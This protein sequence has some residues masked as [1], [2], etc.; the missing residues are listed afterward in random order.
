MA[1]E[2]GEKGK[3]VLITS[4]A[5]RKPNIGNILCIQNVAKATA[6]H[7]LIGTGGVFMLYYILRTFRFLLDI[8]DLLFYNFKCHLSNLRAMNTSFNYN[9]L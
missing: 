9:A 1:T 2:D 8:I 6:H 5:N 3:P 7:D 4:P